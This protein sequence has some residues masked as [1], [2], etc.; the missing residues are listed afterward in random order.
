MPYGKFWEMSVGGGIVK[1]PTTSDI[2]SQK[3]VEEAS[4]ARDTK[5]INLFIYRIYF[6]YFL[7]S[8]K[9]L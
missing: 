6:L 7:E 9:Y 8:T 2:I 1:S 5:D 4:R 3:A